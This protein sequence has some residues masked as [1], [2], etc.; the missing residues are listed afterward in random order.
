[1]GISFLIFLQSESHAD[2]IHENEIPNI[3][4]TSLK[5]PKPLLERKQTE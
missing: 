4:F 5:H 1:M 2:I 3:N